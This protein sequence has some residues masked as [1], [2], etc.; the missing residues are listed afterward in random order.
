VPTH[1][2]AM[3]CWQVGSLLPRD[4][5]CINP[6]F[7]HQGILPGDD[8]SWQQLADDLAAGLNTWATGGGSRQLTVKL[9]EIKDPVPGEPNRPK[10]T[11]VLNPGQF[12]DT[13]FPPELCACLSFYGGQ[14]FPRERGRLY[15]PYWALSVSAPGPRPATADRTK[16]NTLAPV[17]AGLGGVD[18]DWIV[19]SPTRKAA[20][21][22]TNYYCDDEWD[23]MRKR[24]KTVTVRTAGTTGG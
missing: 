9:Y 13:S 1:I 20:T 24:G 11:K 10:A 21:K 6:C 17:F 5:N 15:L 4:M 23:N 7:R 2:R 3:C 14:N 8:P 22:V 19:W 16:A 12:T 18:V